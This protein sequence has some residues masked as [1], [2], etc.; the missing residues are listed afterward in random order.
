MQYQFTPATLGRFWA[1]VDQTG[2]CWLWT[3]AQLADGY[4]VFQLA[5]KAVKAHRVSWELAHG[6]IP[7]GLMVCHRCDVPACVRPDHLWLGTCADNLGDAARKG[8]MSHGERH[9]RARLAP[10]DVLTIRASNLNATAL[11]R[12]HGVSICT[13]LDVRKRRTWKHVQAYKPEHAP[14][15]AA[16]MQAWPLEFA[17][18]TRRSFWMLLKSS[19]AWNSSA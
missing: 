6:P 7:A 3:G 1:K 11:A 19:R 10:L 9:F 5:R 2:E 8:R 12:Q 16:T 17:S 15:S 18:T 14:I 4:G 13:I